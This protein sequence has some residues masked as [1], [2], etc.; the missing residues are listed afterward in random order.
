M[1]YAEGTL[2]PAIPFNN[3]MHMFVY[4]FQTLSYVLR[5][6]GF[7]SV[8][9]CEYG[10]GHDPRLLRDSAHRRCESLYVQAQK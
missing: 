1:P 9:R 8:F 2:G 4:D 6:A 10:V 7:N 3:V 5:E